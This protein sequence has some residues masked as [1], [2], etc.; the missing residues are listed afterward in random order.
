MMKISQYREVTLDR[1]D[2]FSVITMNST[3]RTEQDDI[4]LSSLPSG[5]HPLMMVIYGQ[6][7]RET[8]TEL[9]DLGV[10]VVTVRGIDQDYSDCDLYE[11]FCRTVMDNY[12]QTLEEYLQSHKALP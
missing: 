2:D 3:V 6:D 11:L 7:E 10:Y 5:L 8:R 4:V 1:D 9:S 12:D